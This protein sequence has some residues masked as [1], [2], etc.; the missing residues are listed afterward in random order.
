MG[1]ERVLNIA[2]AVMT[3]NEAGNIPKL[4]SDTENSVKNIRNA[5]FTMYII[6]DSS[7]DGTGKVV[8]REAKKVTA[9]NFKVKLLTKNKKEGL[10]G[11]YIWGCLQIMQNNEIDYICEMDADLSHNPKYLKDFVAHAQAGV[12]VVVGSRY[13]KGG[14]IPDWSLKR[15]I[16]S[17]LGN[18]Y[19]RLWL[20]SNFTDWSGGFNMYKVQLLKK[21]DLQT[22]P[23][24]YTFILTL[25]NRALRLTNRIIEVPIVFM[26]RTVG[27]SKIPSSY[28]K[29]VL[30]TCPR[31]AFQN[32]K[33][34]TR[35]SLK[36]KM[37]YVAAFASLAIMVAT[38]L[39]HFSTLFF[40]DNLNRSWRFYLLSD[41][42][43]L[44][45]PLLFKS[46]FEQH[47]MFGWISSSQLFLFPEGV[48]YGISYVLTLPFSQ[49]LVASLYV[50]S[51]FILL[52]LFALLY[53]IFKEITNK[54]KIKSYLYALF[55]LA[56]IT[57]TMLLEPYY[58]GGTSLSSFMM[59]SSYYPG[60]LLTILAVIWATLVIIRKSPNTLNA[61]LQNRQLVIIASAIT[62]IEAAAIVCDA[63]GLLYIVAPM[64]LAV[65][66]AFIVNT[67]KK[68]PAAIL[69]AI[70]T[71]SVGIY[72][73]FRH[74][75]TYRFL[76]NDLSF[77]INGV[78]EA[79]NFYVN[80]VLNDINR[81]LFS[82]V[83][84]SMFA[85]FF[86]ASI[87]V[88]CLSLYKT[89]RNVGEENN[90]YKVVVLLS[91][92]TIMTILGIVASNL[93]GRY[94][95]RYFLPL[96]VLLPLT[97]AAYLATLGKRLIT[98]S[99]T[100]ILTIATVGFVG[101]NIYSV[102]KFNNGSLVALG[103]GDDNIVCS[104]EFI[105]KHDGNV[106]SNSWLYARALDLY[107]NDQRTLPF[108]QEGMPSY[109]INNKYSYQH[110][111][112]NIVAK[113]IDQQKFDPSGRQSVFEDAK[114][115]TDM[116][117]YKDTAEC[118]NGAVKLYYY[119]TGSTEYQR[120]N[121]IINA[122]TY[123]AFGWN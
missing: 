104:L 12:E 40:P 50:S 19:V 92:Y 103:K 66:F 43:S 36:R 62:L 55:V 41:G 87:I 10:G 30:F 34:M 74:F 59:I 20:G 109:W 13:I 14:A 4:L 71:L 83:E 49:H 15:K 44:V 26:D 60:I 57:G 37:Q 58:N 77:N 69:L 79:V 32:L 39:L 123:Q 70:Q 99:L 52:T 29:E 102:T 81:H 110:R 65:I 56:F 48:L 106:A 33:K 35:A 38:S 98:K 64:T 116:T 73:I 5:N 80:G 11:A 9:A 78:G 85:V 108:Y 24:S 114:E 68:T 22:L 96:V 7:P 121:T 90:K 118:N 45:I 53:F 63:L 94:A 21:L 46:V 89:S 117:G 100:I 42:D 119:E 72:F 28:M 3:Y 93:A 122:K 61:F 67:V 101:A 27:E 115:F 75:I 105:N 88:F 82:R 107:D 18:L 76:T 1:K 54:D 8:Q 86:I 91:F 25:K 95:T 84:W 120:L 16:M 47:E 17:I 112:Y 51:M 111:S 6:D 2:L 97:V 31:L 23:K 113:V